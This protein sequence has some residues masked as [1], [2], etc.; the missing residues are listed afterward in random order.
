MK[1][2]FRKLAFVLVAMTAKKA[3][4]QSSVDMSGIAPQSRLVRRGAVGF[5]F[6]VFTDPLNFSGSKSGSASGLVMKSTVGNGFRPQVRFGGNFS[7][8]SLDKSKVG[9]VPLVSPGTGQA[10]VTVDNTMIAFNAAARISLPY[11]KKIIP[12]VDLSAGFTDFSA[13]MIIKPYDLQQKTSSQT[14]YDFASFNYGGAAGIMF[15]LGDYWRLD[16]GIMYSSFLNQGKIVDPS[17]AH[18]ENGSVTV[19]RIPSPV[20][21]MTFKVGFTYCFS[22]ATMGGSSYNSGYRSR[23]YHHSSSHIGHSGGGHVSIHV[24]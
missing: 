24:R 7:Y 12:Y 8:M 2:T 11:T 14:F 15:A 20:D 21:M 16:V 5:G 17:T 22:T 18:L 6:E 23:S 9:S 13:G 19:D 4:A 1:S 3:S 10:D